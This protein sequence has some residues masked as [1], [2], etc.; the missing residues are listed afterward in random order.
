VLCVGLTWFRR[1]QGWAS[2]WPEGASSVVRKDWFDFGRAQMVHKP[3]TA[4]NTVVRGTAKVLSFARSFVP[5]VSSTGA[6]AMA[7]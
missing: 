6:L 3:T 7:A 2:Y 5:T 1:V 4:K